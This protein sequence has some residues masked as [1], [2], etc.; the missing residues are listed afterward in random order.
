VPASEAALLVICGESEL[1][2]DGVAYLL[3]LQ[4]RFHLPL[5]YEQITL[6]QDAR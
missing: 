4:T 2:A 3:Q 6:P 5:A 1:D